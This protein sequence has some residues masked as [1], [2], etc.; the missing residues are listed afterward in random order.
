[1]LRDLSDSMGSFACLDWIALGYALGISGWS[2]T[3]VETP[4]TMA[5]YFCDAFF[6][7]CAADATPDAVLYWYQT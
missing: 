5:L 7:M 6:E 4:N 3:H 1:V 2:L